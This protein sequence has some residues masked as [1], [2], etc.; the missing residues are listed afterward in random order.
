MAY[1]DSQARGEVG[2]IAAGHTTAYGNAGSL[3]HERD[4]EL[5]LQPHGS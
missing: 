3:T 2:A 4:Q 5:N 1:G